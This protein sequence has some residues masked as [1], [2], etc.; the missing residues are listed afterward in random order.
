MAGY[1]NKGFDIIRVK[2]LIIKDIKGELSDPER[3]QLQEWID[4]SPSNKEAYDD[5][6][7][8]KTL[9]TGFFIYQQA[10]SREEAAKQKWDN[11]LKQLVLG[12]H[13]VV[14]SKFLRWPLIRTAAAAILLLTAGAAITYQVTKT[15]QAPQLA[16]AS[17][18]DLAPGGNKATLTLSDGRQVALDSL[19]PGT[20]AYQGNA[21]VTKKDNSTLS[22]TATDLH[23]K[24]IDA[25]DPIR[26]NTLSTPRSGT[27]VLEL[28]DHSK[29]WLNNASSIHYPT[30]FAGQD[31]RIVE[32][33]G[34]AYF[35]VAKDPAHPFKVKVGAN[36]IN[37]L[38]TEFN[39]QAY[40]DEPAMQTTLISGG[41]KVITGDKDKLLS[42]GEQAAVSNE[43]GSTAIN[44]SRPENLRRFTAWKDGYFVFHNDNLQTVMREL[45]RW[46]N[47]EI[48]Y[49]GR[50]PDDLFAG[51]IRR[52]NKA[53]DVLKVLELSDAHFKIDADGQKIIV[54]P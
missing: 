20:L 44:V 54:T 45:S 17:A 48:V 47:V 30:S 31:D 46:Y 6:R 13:K 35:Q 15:H 11:R 9:I 40:S 33:T 12:E 37:V 39:V 7:N 53:S 42:P 36:I 18:T 16:A 19:H 38:G 27:Y 1:S 25:K 8:D 34:E 14:H 2:E 49:K 43:P 41:V 52:D 21:H 23:E 51:Q 22:Y 32:L 26:F 29:V 5:M 24:P 50:I 28:P 3:A 10:A 4:L